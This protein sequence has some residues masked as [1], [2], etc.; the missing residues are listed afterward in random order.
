VGP[1]QVA[2]ENKDLRAAIA[3]LEERLRTRDSEE[4]LCKPAE[5]ALRESFLQYKE[6]FDNTPVCLFVIE[7]T[8]DGRF[9]LA[10]I[11]R[12]EEQV[13]GLSNE[14]TAGRFIEEVVSKE[15]ADHVTRNY[16]RCVEAGRAIHFDDD[17]NLPGGQHWHTT[18]IPLRD[19]E[20][21]INRI[22]GSCVDISDLKRT[23]EEALAKQ[24]LEGLGV[25]AGGIAHDFNNLLGGIYAH[26][27]LLEAELAEGSGTCERVQ[28]IK[29]SAMRGSEIVREL[30]VYA[31]NDRPD[32]V[33]AINV[34][35]LVHQMLELL[36]V[37]ISKRAVLK[38]DIAD[39]IPLALGNA[40]QLRQIVMNLV[41]NASEAIGE[42][43]GVITVTTAHERGTNSPS[44]G[45][46]KG[47]FLRLEVS[48]TGTGMT[49]ATKAK[50]F[51]PFFTT[52]FAGRGMGLAVV[53][54]IVRDH[55]GSIDVRSS[56]GTGTTFRIFLPCVETRPSESQRVIPDTKLPQPG[57]RT[58]IVLVVEDEEAL[59]TAVSRAL[60]KAGCSVLEA[61]DGSSAMELLRAH[62]DDLDA[63]FLDVTLPGISSQE[64]FEEACRMR[65]DL[66]MVVTSAY[67]KETVGSSFGG[68]AA[69]QFIR[70]PYRLGDV[71]RLLQGAVSTEGT[72]VRT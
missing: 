59:R 6:I 70:K 63:I 48:D 67:S 55:G 2:N 31:G 35:Q 57:T 27:E 43:P 30:M 56:P 60:R 51:D 8:R 65:H 69:H 58:G 4:R 26:A 29:H 20:G 1:E 68:L 49:E 11:N 66:R 34:S 46:P 41:I 37:S 61:G 21:V 16:R 32:R 10:A 7:V 44:S 13:V 24:N 52:K 38:T 54:G 64:I 17:L 36:R 45:R 12:A 5:A 25:L 3:E 18:L 22:I 47:N 39:D 53:K 50:I 62:K 42:K 72:A 28:T 15:L 19:S 23:Q 71:V 14:E 9:K 40:S 33:E